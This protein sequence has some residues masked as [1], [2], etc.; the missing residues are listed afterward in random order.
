MRPILALTF[1]LLVAGAAAAQPGPAPGYGT[2]LE[3]AQAYAQ[4]EAT[5]AAE[6]P[7]GY[8]EN[9]TAPGAVD[10]EVRHSA[11]MA[12]W[13]ADD[14][15][16]ESQVCDAYYTPRGEENTEVECECNTT[17]PAE[18]F[19]KETTADTEAL[20]GNATD[21]AKATVEDPQ[22]A[23]EHAQGF[24]D[25]VQ[26]YA[27]AAKDRAVTFVEDIIQGAQ[28][29]LG[30]GLTGGQASLDGLGAVATLLSDVVRMGTATVADVATSTGGLIADAG[31]ATGEALETAGDAIAQA[32]R[33]LADAVTDLFDGKPTQSTPT[34]PVDDLVDGV[35]ETDGLLDPVEELL[36]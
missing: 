2:A 20:A 3:Y 21:F 4:D 11:Y 31:R 34:D 24:L 27:G 15:G 36:S 33:T 5:D 22:N 7:A 16:L 13:A 9:K 17:E 12:C 6:D 26:A 19:V 28:D 14:A 23:T 8:G 18:A 32:A 25:A 1:L 30:L 29:C 35:V 10:D